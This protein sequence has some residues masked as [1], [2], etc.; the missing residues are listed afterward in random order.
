MKTLMKSVVWIVGCVALAG[1]ASATDWM[2]YQQ[3]FSI[4]CDGYS[5]SAPL[6]NFPV[7]VKL[8]AHIAGF[9]Y[10]DLQADGV[11]LRFAD[12]NG[13]ELPYEV[14]TWNTAGTSYVW[15]AVSELTASASLKAYYANPQA[16]MPAY[17]T[18]GTVWSNDHVAV[19]HM[20]TNETLKVGDSTG[21]GFAGAKG[22]AS[23]VVDGL[24]GKAVRSG[25]IATSGD[26]GVYVSKSPAGV[27]TN[28]AR[29]SISGWIQPT[30]TQVQGSRFI[31]HKAG[32][33]NADGWESFCYSG[34]SLG[35]RGTNTSK[36]YSVSLPN[37]LKAGA[38]WTHL[39]IV[40]EDTVIRFYTNGLLATASLDTASL[41]ATA[42]TGRGI[43]LGRY[44]VSG[45]QAANTALGA[46]MDE[47]RYL[48][49]PASAEWAQA[50]YATVMD[51]AFLTY[52]M[53][54]PNSG[55]VVSILSL[56]PESIQ[57][58]SAVLTGVMHMGDAPTTVSLAWGTEP[59]AMTD[60]MQVGIFNASGPVVQEL[61][62]LE[63]ETDYYYS[64][65]AVSDDGSA[66]SPVA[67]FRTV[68]APVLGVASATNVQQTGFFSVELLNPGVDSATVRCWVGLAPEE[69]ELKHEWTEQDLPVILEHELSGLNLDGVYYY[70]FTA[71]NS[72][73]DRVFSV[74]TATNS[75]TMKGGLTWTGEGGN[76]FWQTA[77]NWSPSA[78][79]HSTLDTYFNLPDMP[80][81]LNAN[82]TAAGI[83][84]QQAESCNFDLGGHTLSSTN[85][86]VGQTGVATATMGNGVWEV[87][88]GARIGVAHPAA[89]GSSLTVANGGQLSASTL[90]VGPVDSRSRE[91]R[92][93]VEN[94]GAVQI[95]GITTLSVKSTTD[96]GGSNEIRVLAGGS[97]TTGGVQTYPRGN[98]FVI[99]GGVATNTGSFENALAE[100]S[101]LASTLYV[102]NGGFLKQKGNL[103][104]NCC[105]NGRL[106]VLNNAVLEADQA[107]YVGSS[108]SDKG[109]YGLFLLS[110]ATVRVGG[111][112]EVPRDS[113]HNNE[114]MRVMEDPGFETLL[115][116]GTDLTIGVGDYDNR[117]APYSNYNNEFV[118]NGGRVT[119]AQAMTVG[120][121]TAA[122]YTNNLVSIAGRTA[123]VTA[124]TLKVCNAT[125]LE[126]QI[127]DG[128]FANVPLDISDTATIDASTKLT[129]DL[130][131]LPATQGGRFVLV[132][133]GSL[134]DNSIPTENVTVLGLG[135]RTWQLIQTNNEVVF[136]LIIP[137]AV[138]SLY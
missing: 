14:D 99:D 50:E 109:G 90:G 12:A 44:A 116:I 61:T 41:S 9:D 15:V 35:A 114:K 80:I 111:S 84:V 11:D 136:K 123:H 64:F 74:A 59:N 57:A 38:P 101:A 47:F 40:Y 83:F 20:S 95:A 27:V 102:A 46:V 7:L 36:G 49:F 73:G 93:V 52:S 122:I 72:Y 132:K 68:G 129:I 77:A 24:I 98:D 128:G 30:I 18:D 97:L 75:L 58:Q 96:Q 28:A 100:G 32:S 138:M 119:V 39:M 91:N 63:P 54:M 105:W 19:W 34:T 48:Q 66:T 103:H 107:L 2:D 106:F 60:S 113:R 3:T 23:T 25:N 85:L 108:V 89:N 37:E 29:F 56:E 33:N 76:T 5:G 137:P 130:S 78:V 134:A 79:P 82:G 86:T 94:G 87:S 42:V 55:S 26:W 10:A 104:V 17:R 69:L 67:M 65:S 45:S 6:A 62:E 124:Q 125:R 4:T 135:Q 22:S 110:N 8:G 16:V 71:E 112:V 120:R 53:V 51:N 117:P 131:Q 31:S 1:S 81:S 133:A 126:L 127:P 115:M 43:G 13:N 88:G 121:A 21:H 92:L 70:A 118:L